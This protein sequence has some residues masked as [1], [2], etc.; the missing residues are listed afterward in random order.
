[1]YLNVHSHFSLRYGALSV[2]ELVAQARAAGVEVLAL[3]DINNTSAAYDFVKACRDAGIKPVVGIEFRAENQLRFIGLARNLQGFQE[4]NEFLSHHL[5][6]QEP[7][8]ENAPEFDHVYVIYPQG[9]HSPRSLREN[10]FVGVKSTEVRALFSSPFRQHQHKL[11]MLHPVTFKDKVSRNLHRLLVAI[12]RNTLLSKLN[13]E[14][15]AGE[16]EYMLPMDQLLERYADYPGIVQNTRRVLEECN[17]EFEFGPS[18]NRSNFTGDR[19]DDRSLL[20]KL[21]YDGLRYRYGPDDR[22]H[23]ARQRVDRELDII[24]RLDFSS[25]FLITWDFV[26]Y[27]QSR[28]F[29][30]VGRG[31]GANS[32]VAY[33]MGITDVDPIELDLYFERFLNPHRTSPP[34]FDIDFSWR[35]RDEVID[36][37][38]KR[39]G[40]RHTAML[41]TYNTFQSRSVIRELGKVFGLPKE[42]IDNL[43]AQRKHPSTPDHISKLIWRYGER[44]HGMPNHLGV[45]PGGILISDRP[46]NA[47]TATS[48]PP[49]GFPITHFDMF[50]AEDVGLYKFDILS[51]RGLGHIRDAGDLI[52]ENRGQRIDLHDVQAFKKDT[53]VREQ[54]ESGKTMGC[55]YVESPAMR[56]LLTKLQCKTYVELVAASSIIRPGVAKSGMMREYIFRHNNPD[57]FEHLHP[58]MGEL[59]AETYG[60]MVY[61]E[62]VIKV[63]HHFAGLGLGEA[64]VL[65]RVMSGKYRNADDKFQRLQEKFFGNC[66]AKGYPQ[67]VTQE[68]WRQIESFSGYS[69]S[70][71][72]SASFAV[73]SYQS[74]FLKA[75]YP[76]EFMV[77]VINNFGGFYATE[78]YFHE[79]RMAGATVHA[80]CINHSSYLTSLKDKDI[81]MGM[82]HLKSLGQE[83]GAG[84]PLERE[85]NGPFRDLDDLVRRVPVGLEQLVILIRIG[86]L[87]FTGLSKKALLWRAHLAFAATPDRK[88]STVL[89]APPPSQFSLPNLPDDELEDIYDQVEILGY[90]IVSPFSLLAE[91]PARALA[92]KAMIR[93]L[94]QQVIMVGYLV[95]TKH[96]R[97][98][99]GKSMFFG[100]FLDRGGAMFDTVH[101]P[102]SFEGNPF[103]GGGIYELVGKIVEDFGVPALEVSK[104]RRLSLKGDPR[105][106]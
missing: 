102:N 38:F 60:V 26:R 20:R 62:D 64:D 2:E 74:L 101:F 83:I 19:R 65:R 66:Q 63:A 85:R 80:P 13:P 1:M 52:H 11:V 87:R 56:Q 75:H 29:F 77:A 57:K 69:F 51:Q 46:I 76:I 50:V 7:L 79:A 54:L 14:D 100:N 45:H 97:T 58:K 31:S 72:H 89:F 73:E 86:A 34:D 59:M 78:F 105:R 39:Y 67:D 21:A 96:V 55:F 106:V 71:A 81:W 36:Y 40:T 61:Q 9:Y 94:N 37:V 35:D 91:A 33:C 70:K 98:S 12:D 17:F 30:H 88:Q 48:V 90:P 5:H 84:I 104:M 15:Y 95:T 47:V 10:E 25:Y 99:N 4:L 22:N 44:L 68:V 28:N 3:T 93:Y 41:A 32:I 49:K 43:V 42:E 16:D 103:V 18:R 8:P 53:K 6:Q 82:I 92:A 23:E 27:A 24:D